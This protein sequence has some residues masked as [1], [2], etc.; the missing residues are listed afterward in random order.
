[1]QNVDNIK[2]ITTSYFKEKIWCNKEREDKRKLRYYE[3]MINPILEYKKYLSILTSV[4]KEIK[5][6]KIRIDFH[7]LHRTILKTLRDERIC[8]LCDTKRVEEKIT[9][10]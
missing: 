2:S 10:S 1:M 4:K 7:K 6:G 9:F 5:I 3:E 8:H